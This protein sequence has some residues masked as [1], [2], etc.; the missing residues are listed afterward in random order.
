MAGSARCVAHRCNWLPPSRAFRR[1]AS[2]RGAP[3][4]L[5]AGSPSLKLAAT[6]SWGWRRRR[7]STRRRRRRFGT[8]LAGAAPSGAAP[9]RRNSGHPNSAGGTLSRALSA[10][11]LRRTVRKTLPPLA[12]IRQRGRKR[13]RSCDGQKSASHIVHLSNCVATEL[14]TVSS[15]NHKSIG[16]YARAVPAAASSRDVTR[17]SLSLPEAQGPQARQGAAW[18]VILACDSRHDHPRRSPPGPY[19]PRR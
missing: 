1:G 4:P 12:R 14:L 2:C 16:F 15:K 6:R 17:G 18:L 10:A 3:E 5:V 9:V 19:G 11:A 8:R 13:Q 7:F